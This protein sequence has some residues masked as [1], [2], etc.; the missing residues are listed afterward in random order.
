MQSRE[1]SGFLNCHQL[2]SPLVPRAGMDFKL[3]Y[4][5]DIFILGSHLLLWFARQGVFEQVK[6]S[7]N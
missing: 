6:V 1:S 4:N 3:F 7:L 5:K 2:F